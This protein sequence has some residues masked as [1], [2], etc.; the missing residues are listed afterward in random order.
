MNSWQWI[1]EG[2]IIAV[3]AEQIAEHGGKNGLRDRGLLS[4]ALARPRNIAGYKVPTVFDLAAAYAYGIVKN[5]PFI[6]GN[7]RTGFLVAYIFLAMNG[8]K[9]TASEAS[10]VEA[11]LALASG[12]MSEAEFADWLKTQSIR[13]I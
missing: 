6:D 12:G 4:S 10:A 11:V 3:H 8:W 7:K 1:V 2:V 5:H 13:R 9:L